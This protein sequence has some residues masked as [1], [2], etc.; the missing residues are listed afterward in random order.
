MAKNDERKKQFIRAL[1][2]YLA[3]TNQVKHS[4]GLQLGKADAQEWANLRQLSP[5]FGYPT[6]EE[7]EAQLTEFLS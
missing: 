4:I 1:A 6:V 2:E 3:G 5:L 7:A